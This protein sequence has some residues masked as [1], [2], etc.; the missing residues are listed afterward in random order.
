MKTNATIKVIGTQSDGTDTDKIE[1]SS[2]GTF[3]EI[4]NGI[5][6]VYEEY[7]DV[8]SKIV[9]TLTVSGNIV[10]IK[11]KGEVETN[12][13]VQN[14]KH[15]ICHY[16]TSVGEIIMGT[17]GEELSLKD[18]EVHLAYTLD[19]NSSVVSRNKVDIKYRLEQE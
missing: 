8:N 10:Q 2:V 9:T 13:I 16:D 4:N 5:R 11:R 6:L 3:E 1:I 18:G 19:M 7:P 17:Y 15:H 14:G 12:M